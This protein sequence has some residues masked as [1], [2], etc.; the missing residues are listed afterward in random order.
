MLLENIVK[1]S[2]TINL[3]RGRGRFSIEN[4]VKKHKLPPVSTA[5]SD[6]TEGKARDD[7]KSQSSTDIPGTF[8]PVKSEASK[9]GREQGKHKINMFFGERHTRRMR[10]RTPA[11]VVGNLLNTF[12]L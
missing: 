2:E 12:C 11:S 8:F 7:V 5:Q 10:Y 9:E 6:D 1:T 3:R 4:Q